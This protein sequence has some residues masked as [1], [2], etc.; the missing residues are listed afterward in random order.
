M[1]LRL[2]FV[3]AI[4]TL[5]SA[6]TLRAQE[7]NYTPSKDIKFEERIHDFGTIKEIDGTV[8]HRFKFTNTGKKSVVILYPRIGCSC[9]KADFPQD[10]IKPGKSAY[11]TVS[12]NPAYRPGSFSKEIA[13]VSDGYHYNRIW[14]KGNVI[15]AQHPVSENYPYK[16]GSGLW[17]N[18]KK[19]LFGYVSQGGTK[20]VWLKFANDTDQVMRL[21]FDYGDN[22]DLIIPASH[23]LQPHS[24]GEMELIYTASHKL[25]NDLTIKIYP[26][27]NGTRL[28]T[29]LTATILAR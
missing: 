24:N 8:S 4:I 17:M 12:Y 16:Y 22:N 21:S 18:L 3:I 2:S 7:S 25:T 27:V 5:F 10:E 9:V 11:I 6:L 28:T 19:A 13:V 1:N 20:K 15:A 23:I 29:P 26:I 14:V